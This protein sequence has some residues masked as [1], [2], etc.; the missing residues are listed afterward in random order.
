MTRPGARIDQLDGLRAIAALAVIGFH[1]N[2]P[3]ATG[4]KLGVD[5]FFVLSG[6]LITGLLLAELDRSDHISFSQFAARRAARLIPALWILLAAAVA[7]QP[8]LWRNALLASTFTMNFAEA[9]GNAPN[10]LSPT[11]SLAGE[12]QFYLIWPFV[13]LALSRL[14]QRKAQLVLVGLWILMT[15]GRGAWLAAGGS[16]E[17]AYFLPIFHSTG[18]IIGSALAFRPPNIR[19]GLIGLPLVIAFLVFAPALDNREF[20]SFAPGLEL[21]TAIVLLDPPRLLAWRPLVWLGR[22][23]YGVYLWQGPLVVGLESL[24]PG[25]LFAVATALSVGI[26]TLSYVLVERPLIK[27][28]NAKLRPVADLVKSV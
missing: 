21:A 19:I 26:A 20:A 3:W 25:P 23:S 5:V 10:S 24:A 13:V 11:W 22:I 12:W 8:S 16:P 27:S 1:C 15:V 6:R 7:I 14:G 18:L 9:F 2:A 28:V 17:I 4:G